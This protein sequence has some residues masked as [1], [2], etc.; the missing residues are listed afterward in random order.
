[1]K[2]IYLFIATWF[3]WVAV[4][5]IWFLPQKR[6]LLRRV[7]NLTNDELIQL[8]RSG[9]VEAQRLRRRTWW[10]MGIGLALFLPQVL[11][12]QLAKIHT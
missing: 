2:L 7:G 8:A 9:D 3:I 12:L 6:A 5:A 10:F 1:M 4:G 11:F